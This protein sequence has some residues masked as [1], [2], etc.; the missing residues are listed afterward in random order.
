MRPRTF[1]ALVLTALLLVFGLALSAQ[2]DDQC[3]VYYNHSGYLPTQYD[4]GVFIEYDPQ[5]RV[6]SEHS[7]NPQDYGA[8]AD[9]TRFTNAGR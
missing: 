6:I 5:V 4:Y 1:L 8:G 9:G 2:A 7:E 3:T